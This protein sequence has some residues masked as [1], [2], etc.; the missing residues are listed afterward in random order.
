MIAVLR[1]NDAPDTLLDAVRVIPRD[2]GTPPPMPRGPTPSP[3]ETVTWLLWTVHHRPRALDALSSMALAG[4]MAPEV[5][6]AL[7]ALLGA[8]DA[9]TVWPAAWLAAGGEEATLRAVVARRLGGS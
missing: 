8:R 2:P 6:A 5:G 7:G 3:T 9:I 1:A 4:G